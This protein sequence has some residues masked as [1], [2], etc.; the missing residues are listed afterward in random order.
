MHL[1]RLNAIGISVL[2]F[3]LA[4]CGSSIEN[5][6]QNMQRSNELIQQNTATV[7]HSSEVIAKNTEAVTLSTQTLQESKTVIAQNTAFL[8]QMV[9]QLSLH[10]FLLPISF[11]L[12]LL[13]LFFPSFFLY[14][15]Y[16]SLCRKMEP[17]FGKIK[18]GQ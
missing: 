16:R 12:I 7:Q 18:K 17:L 6:N 11:A 1:N 5:M 14:L 13:A 2:F 8:G 10:P 3:I 15:A 4:G 9:E